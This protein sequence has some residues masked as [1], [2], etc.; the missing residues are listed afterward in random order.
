ML[1]GIA[2]HHDSGFELD[3]PGVLAGLQDDRDSAQLLHTQVERGSRP[4]RRIQ[5][6]ERNGL[7]FQSI[8]DGLLLQA[9]RDFQ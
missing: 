3:P 8:L 5:K 1:L 4:H 2:I 7:A 6:H 9:G